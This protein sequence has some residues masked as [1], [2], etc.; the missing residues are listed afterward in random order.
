M[1]Q[2]RQDLARLAANAPHADSPGAVRFGPA[3]LAGLLRCG[4]CRRRMTV[5]YHIDAG[6]P[7]ISYDCGGAR[8]EFGGPKCQHLS[9]ACLDAFVTAQVLAAIAPAAAEASLKAAEQT[10][11]GRA[12]RDKI[13]RLRQERAQI[14]VDR[15]RRCC[16]LAEPENRLVV[17]QLEHDWEQ[18]LAAQQVLTED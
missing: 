13:W 2:H 10:L 4:R 17:R 14:D 12:E 15:A 3:L 8:A 18:A 6:V 1:D 5:T 16:R 11:T 9:G 7:R